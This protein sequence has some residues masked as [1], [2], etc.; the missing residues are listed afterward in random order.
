M[1]SMGMRDHYLNHGYFPG[2]IA[3]G[4]IRKMK[5]WIRLKPVEG[6][7]LFDW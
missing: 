2:M 5:S 6:G 3:G 4:R 7:N 1:K